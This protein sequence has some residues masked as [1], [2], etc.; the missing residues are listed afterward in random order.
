MPV[1]MSEPPRDVCSICHWI[2]MNEHLTNEEREA[3]RTKLCR[4][5][6]L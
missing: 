6:Q 5:D 3:L 4:K 1:A 2:N